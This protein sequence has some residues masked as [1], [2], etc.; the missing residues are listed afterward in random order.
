MR[1]E[2]AARIER[3]EEEKVEEAEELSLLLKHTIGMREEWDG[4]GLEKFG[5]S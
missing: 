2:G 3:G 4:G 5:L 1:R